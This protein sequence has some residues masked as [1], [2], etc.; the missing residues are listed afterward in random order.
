MNRKFKKRFVNSNLCII[1]SKLNW[2]YYSIS[3]VHLNSKLP[4]AKYYSYMNSNHFIKYN[5]YSKKYYSKYNVTTYYCN[6]NEIK[7][8]PGLGLTCPPPAPIVAA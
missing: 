8:I 4:Y 5:S 2:I 3:Y 6:S 1:Y 7:K